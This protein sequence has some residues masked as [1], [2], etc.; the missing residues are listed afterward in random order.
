MGLAVLV[1]SIVAS[2]AGENGTIGLRNKSLPVPQRVQTAG[3]PTI[4]KAKTAEQGNAGHGPGKDF[5]WTSNADG[6]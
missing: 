3:S 4:A 5:D 6:N 1:V 2:L